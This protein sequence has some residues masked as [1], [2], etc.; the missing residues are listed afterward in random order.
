MVAAIRE[1]ALTALS[2]LRLALIGVI[3]VSFVLSACGRKGALD[4]PPRTAS[5]AVPPGQPSPTGDPNED[6]FG[7]PVVSKGQKKGFPLDAILN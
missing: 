3:A 2:P 4:P 7:N 6:E 5:Q 1:P